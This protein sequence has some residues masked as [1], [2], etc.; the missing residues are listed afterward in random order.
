MGPQLDKLLSIEGTSPLVLWW[1]RR[2]LRLS[3]NLALATALAIGQAV[4][5]VWVWDEQLLRSAYMSAK[6]LA[7]LQAGLIALDQALRQRGSYL[8]VRRGD[9]AGQLSQLLTETAAQTIVAEADYSPYARARDEQIG[10]MLPLQWVDGLVVHRPGQIHKADGQP[11][12]VF[13]PF[14]KV[15]K[16][17]P[18]PT[19]FLPAPASIP[20]PP[21]IP[22]LALE[23]Q[24]DLVG[25]PAGEAEAQ[26]RLQAFI[27][28]TIADY[29][30]GRDRLDRAGTSALSPYLRFGM[31]SANQAVLA[32]SQ[33]MA[34][35]PTPQAKR[36]A[37]SWLNE[38]IWREFYVHILYH[39]PFVRRQPFRHN[40]QGIVWRDARPEFE[41]WCAGQ[42]GY[43]IVDAAMRQLAQTGWMP[44]RARM[45]VASFLSKD[46]LLNWQWGE[47]WFMQQLLDGDPAANNG[48]WQWTAGVG[49]DAAP[50]FRIFNPITQS[51]KH[52]P[53]GTFIRRWLPELAHVPT[54]YIHAPWTMPPAIQQT[55]ACHIG[56]DYPAPIVDHAVARARTLAAYQT[57]EFYPT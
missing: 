8:V 14:S 24:V 21:G 44:N 16:P 48:G 41:A 3:D 31:L 42:T 38:L 47:K 20:T 23:P 29:S 15:W 5:P 18:R 33:A 9:P 30:E 54:A 4:V 36:G 45:I 17:L 40:Y 51:Q 46:L 32:A 43:P 49:T 11:Y 52:D 13:T 22:S 19:S 39:F 35:A 7:F 53:A 6:R 26:R 27:E 10:R 28:T 12:T 55:A 34:Q 56:H 37:E 50:Y 2:D 57:P 25:F 1:I